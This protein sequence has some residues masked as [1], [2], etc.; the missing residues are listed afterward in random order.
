MADVLPRA[1][2]VHAMEGRTR[3][4]VA[5]RRGDEGFF[6][7]VA[8]G[9][10]ALA[11]VHKVEVA[12]LTGGIL[13]FHDAPL[14]LLG[15]AAEKGGLFSLTSEMTEKS[16]SEELLLHLS[17]RMVAGAALGLAAIWQIYKEN[18]FP[19]A[20]TLAWYTAELTLPALFPTADDVSD[21]ED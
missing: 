19:P 10:S 6:A 14:S 16:Q 4:R 9:L 15:E 21:A 8:A 7:S 2:V 18:I 3:L 13:I 17:P 1:A 12:P 20:L 11:G 5:D